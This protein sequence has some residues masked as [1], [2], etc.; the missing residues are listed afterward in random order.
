M[1][2]Y[3]IKKLVFHKNRAYNAY[4]RDKNNTELFNKFQWLQ[5]HIKIST[6]ESEYNFY[7]TFIPFLTNQFVLMTFSLN[8]QNVIY[9]FYPL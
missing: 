5:V 3:N 6:E 9:S 2:D 8:L 7:S 4:S 1:V